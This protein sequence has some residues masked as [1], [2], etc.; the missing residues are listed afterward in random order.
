MLQEQCEENMSEELRCVRLQ[1]F[2]NVASHYLHNLGNLGM[3]G[4]QTKVR[5]V[6]TPGQMLQGQ[7][8]EGMSE[9]LRCVRLQ[10]CNIAA[11]H[12]VHNLRRLG[13]QGQQT[14]VRKVETPGQMLHDQ[15][16]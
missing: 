15:R 8:E 13:M 14:K 2:N 3:Q 9:E 6:E 11:R 10:P 7:C 1:S 5:Q 4:Q 16:Q 12:C